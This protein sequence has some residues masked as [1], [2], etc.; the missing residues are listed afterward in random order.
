MANSKQTVDS[1]FADH[2]MHIAHNVN[3]VKEI[4]DIHYRAKFGVSIF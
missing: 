3:T 2:L 1:A 4:T